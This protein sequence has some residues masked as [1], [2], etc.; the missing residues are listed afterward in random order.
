M[1]EAGG[2]IPTKTRVGA[3]GLTIH[4]GYCVLF[5]EYDGQMDGA[6]EKGLYHCDT[7]LLSRW[8]I[9]ANGAPWRLLDA[10]AIAHNA[11]LVYLLNHEITAE[12][13][14]IE[15]DTLRLRVGRSLDGGM[16]EDLDLAND[17]Q[18]PVRFNLELVLQSDFADLFEVR[19]GAVKTRGRI[20]T[21]W[22]ADEPSMTVTYRNRDFRRGII[23][24]FASPDPPTYANGRMSFEIRLEPHETWRCCVFY[25]FMD[26]DR[27]VRAPRSCIDRLDELVSTARV[28]EWLDNA[29]ELD[30]RNE[31]FEA[32]FDRSVEDVAGLRLPISGTD[33]L[34]F[35]PAGGVPWF[36]APFGRDSLICSYQSTII[37][38]E[39]ARGTLDI[40]GS[41]Q[42]DAPDDFRD[43]Q[44]GKIVHEIRQGELAHFDVIPHTRYYGTAD[45]TILYLIVLHNAWLATGDERLLR[46]H[47]KTAERCLE[48]I[49]QYGDMDG[50][51]FQEYQTQSSAGYENHSWKDA[52]DAIVHPDGSLVDGPKALCELQ[53]YVYDAWRR[54]AQVFSALGEEIRARELER[55][56]AELFDRFNDVFWNEEEGI[57]A[58]ALDG[59]KKPVFTVAS[60]AGH[61]LWS[62]V[63]PTDRAKKIVSRLMAPDM[64]SGWGVRTLSSENAAYDPLSY[65]TGSV[66]PHDNALIALG[67]R[68]YGFVREACEIASEVTAAAGYFSLS[69]IP[70][71][72]SG[73]P[74]VLHA[75]PVKYRNAN[76]PQA[77]AAGAAFAFM[78][79]ML[80][81][82]PDAP[83]GRLYIDPHLPEWLPAISLKNLRVGSKAVDLDVWRDGDRTEWDVVSGDAGLI[84]RRDFQE[85]W[86]FG[87]GASGRDG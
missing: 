60:N 59:D 82:Q 49:D 17:Q 22:S 70:E 62:G 27:T 7:R 32:F 61:C 6:S 31:T 29:L 64:R 24:R 44:P 26:D 81:Y 33:P 75:F 23:V 19:A 2:L 48:W 77:W 30:A 54:M 12:D 57:Y 87:A 3:A 20:E 66:W 56:A 18:R 84:A 5:T 46:R 53:G 72:Y 34:H 4:E 79:A 52:E 74:R 8:N 42:A 11:E 45:S 80:G 55:K 41:L 78:Q 25:D 50:D 39:F 35:V 71:L 68:R 37:N 67:F 51:G 14:P 47:R 43:A 38:P 1:P 10:G 13:G 83:N 40:L 76:A 58:L 86:R 15:P 36:V 16:H 9:Y 63:A 65:Q 73:M 21:T 85:H 69:K 28:R